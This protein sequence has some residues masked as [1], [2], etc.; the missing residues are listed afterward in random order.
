[1]RGVAGALDV[2]SWEANFPPL[3][4][5]NYELTPPHK[6]FKHW[7][8][9]PVGRS[10]GR[11]Y[12]AVLSTYSFNPVLV[13]FFRPMQALLGLPYPLAVALDVPTTHERNAAIAQVEGVVLASKVHLA[14]SGASEDSKSVKKL[15]DC[16]ITLNQLNEGDMLHEVQM[17]IAVAAPDRVGLK[18]AVDDII[19]V[20]KPFFALR[21]NAGE[22]LAESVKFFGLTP[23]RDIKVPASTWQMVSRELALFFAPLGFRKL[24]GLDGTLR[25]QSADGSYPMFLNSWRREKKATHELWVG[26]T[27]SGKTFA[28]N[29]NLA[30]QFAEEGVPF[31]LIEPMGHGEILANALGL[32]WF[33][34]S[35]E[36]TKLNLLD[37][38][39]PDM[40]RQITHVIR[41]FETMLGRQFTGDQLGNHQKSLLGQALVRLYSRW[42]SLDDISPDVAPVIDDLVTVLP[43]IVA[44]KKMREIAKALSDE[45]AGLATG[46]A[47][48]AA[49]VNHRTNLDLSYRGK[50]LPRVFSFHEMGND[51]VLVA[52]TYTQVLSAIQRDALAD[53]RPR[54][55]AVDEV[56]RLMHH[57][58]LLQFLIEAVKTFRT[59]RKKVICIDQNMSLFLRD[60]QTR[61]LFEN[62]PIKVI[63]NQRDG[64]PVFKNDPAFSHYSN[65]HL[66]IIAEAMTGFYLLDVKDM[67]IFYLYNRPSQAEFNRFGKT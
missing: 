47:P 64:M 6:D 20:T 59:R 42:R 41:L 46:D 40:T 11:S 38:M 55:I 67:G 65:Q 12:F 31:D 58:S 48:Y 60:N 36:S 14:T 25:G 30:R 4:D 7:H 56:Y 2:P 33:V 19:N 39:Y 15:T 62:S 35:P 5:G 51:D 24:G 28:L 23:S 66:Q 27:G 49:F 53:E 57:P 45:I 52:L 43:T 44:D 17:V 34:P 16:H 63:F 26:Q 1:V 50:F 22:H 13:T 18:K 8:L 3:F 61:L 10:G 29:V 54:V 9:R 21:P 32:D 37:V